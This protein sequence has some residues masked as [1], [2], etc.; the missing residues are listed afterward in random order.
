MTNMVSRTNVF[1]EDDRRE[2]VTLACCFD[3]LV[4]QLGWDAVFCLDATECICRRVAAIFQV[5]A[6]ASWR[7]PQ[8]SS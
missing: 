1:S 7:R 5:N 2:L 3:A 8:P 4:Q 6:G